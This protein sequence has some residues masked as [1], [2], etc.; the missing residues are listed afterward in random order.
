MEVSGR[1]WARAR[2]PVGYGEVK[3]QDHLQSYLGAQYKFGFRIVEGTSFR[4]ISHG[5]A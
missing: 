5:N 2:N 3:R 4:V 1:A